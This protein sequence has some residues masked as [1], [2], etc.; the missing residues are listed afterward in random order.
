MANNI[1]RMDVA[2]LIEDIIAVCKRHNL[3]LS[4]EDFYGAFLVEKETTEEWLRSAIRYHKET[5]KND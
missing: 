4:H 3:W 2:A 5:T 1:A